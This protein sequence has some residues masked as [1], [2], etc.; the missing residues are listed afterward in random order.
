MKQPGNF[1]ELSLN[2]SEIFHSI[3]G[4]GSMAGLPCV[5]IR[6]QGCNLRCKWCDT[7]YALEIKEKADILTL[8]QTIDRISGYKCKFIEFTG[9]EPLLQKNVLPL[10]QYLAENGYTIAVET[11]GN[12]DIGI[13]P[14]GVIRIMDLKCPSS[15][16]GDKNNFN[17]I[18]KLNEGDNVKFVIADK[19]DYEWAKSIYYEYE[20][21]D[22]PIHLIFSPA[23]GLMEAKELAARILEDKLKVRLQLQLHKYIWHPDKRG[24]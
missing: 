2:V 15:G 19:E 5:F 23:F 20:L 10:M 16:M 17:N 9:G 12:I 4:E 13:T 1:D 7:P 18:E 3:Q 21:Y 14:P 24:V 22:K 6:L 11:N 8:R